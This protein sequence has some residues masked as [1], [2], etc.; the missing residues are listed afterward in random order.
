MKSIRLLLL[1]LILGLLILANMIVIFLFSAQDGTKSAE[2]SGKVTEGVVQVIIKD[3]E[4]LPPI[5][6]DDI[7]QQYHP[8]MRKIAHMAEFCTLGMLIFLFLL[9]WKGKI[10]PRLLIALGSTFLYACSDELHQMLS[11]SR[12]PRFSDVMVDMLGAAAGCILILFVILLLRIYRRIT[13]SN[14]TVTHYKVP[15]KQGQPTLRIAVAADLHGNPHTRI[16]EL[17]R[18]NAPDLIL[19]PGDLTD[20]KELC[21]E[22]SP[23]YDFLRECASLAPTFYSYGNHEI[24]CYHKGKHWTH[25]VPRDLPTEVAV[26]ISQTGVTLLDDEY[27]EWNGIYVC[28]VRSGLNGKSN[29][30][31]KE[32]LARFDTL[33]GYRILLCHHPEYYIPYVKET[34][35]QLTVCGHAHGGQWRFFGR[36]VFSP[37]QGIFP[38]YTSGMLEERCV[39]S[40]GL[41]NHT[42]I[43]RIFNAPELVIIETESISKKQDQEKGD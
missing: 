20:D 43:P 8:P 42:H 21:K 17:L 41:G 2:T 18:Q 16:A 35:I 38:K 39:I 24:S 37:G 34:K 7:V 4:K 40:R 3:F 15:A 19:I 23:A 1:R 26:R 31:N 22:S 10:L 28:G 14:V 36:G 27:A 9:T 25:P 11:E 12:G 13:D 29:C 6:Q 32:A 5:Q 30:P 33:N